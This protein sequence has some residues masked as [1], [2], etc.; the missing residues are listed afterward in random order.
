MDAKTCP[1]IL[2]EIDKNIKKQVVVSEFT[3]GL[4]KWIKKDLRIKKKR[5]FGSVDELIVYIIKDVAK[6]DISEYENKI[7]RE[8]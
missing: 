4:L 7:D 1:D 6:Y 3:H 5:I 8:N 2:D